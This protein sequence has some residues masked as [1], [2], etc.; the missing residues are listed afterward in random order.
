MYYIIYRQRA[1]AIYLYKAVNIWIHNPLRYTWYQILG[2]ENVVP[3]TWYQVFG[4][5]YSVLSD[6]PCAA[7]V[8]LVCA[9]LVC[10][11]CVRSLCV[12]SM[13]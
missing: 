10:S 13:Q 11:L 12:R 1:N 5:R 3:G 2:T 7:C 8:Q 6:V 4:T 9:Q